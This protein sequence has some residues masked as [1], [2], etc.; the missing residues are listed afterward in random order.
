M[1]YAKL[2]T[3]LIV[4][5]GFTLAAVMRL[6]TMRRFCVWEMRYLSP[7]QAMDTYLFGKGGDKLSME[8]KKER[9]LSR[10]IAYP[11]C[12]SAHDQPRR[13]GLT[14]DLV[15]MLYLDKEVERTDG[16]SKKSAMGG[17]AFW[18]NSCGKEIDVTGLSP[19]K[20][21]AF[22]KGEN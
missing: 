9:A 6:E 15:T 7:Q 4:F 8:D 21:A 5:T 11:E 13:K 1:K 18:L 16:S 17:Y 22:G 20:A 3:I 10:K 19:P 14:I 12:C 2:I